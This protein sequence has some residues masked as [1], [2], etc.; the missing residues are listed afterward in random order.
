M[1]AETVAQPLGGSGWVVR[2]RLDALRAFA[3]ARADAL[4]G[5]RR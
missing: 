1:M 3:D 2:H 4:Q 5:G